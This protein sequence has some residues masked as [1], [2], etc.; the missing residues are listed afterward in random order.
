[1]GHMGATATNHPGWVPDNTL[2]HRLLLVR[3]QLGLSQREACLRSAI[4]FGEWQGMES[5]RQVRALDIKVAKIAEAFGVDRDWL[6]WG[7]T[8]LAHVA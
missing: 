2:S 4:P 3:A 8:P 7:E 5:G 1:M 6:L